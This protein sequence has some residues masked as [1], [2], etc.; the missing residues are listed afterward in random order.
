[1][2]V[3][4]QAKV[5]TD[6]QINRWMEMDIDIESVCMCNIDININIDNKGRKLKKEGRREQA[7]SRED[8]F[9]K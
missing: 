9:Y 8:Y 2:G 3:E 6:E 4:V 1:M 7:P 5:W